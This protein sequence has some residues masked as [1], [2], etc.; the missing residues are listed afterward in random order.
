[1]LPITE[2]TRVHP[3]DPYAA[4]KRA[5]DAVCMSDVASCGMKIV[6]TRAFSH[7]GPRRDVLGEIASFARQIARAERRMAE[8]EGLS[9]YHSPEDMGLLT[10][11]RL[12]VLVHLTAIT[13]HEQIES[14]RFETLRL[15]LRGKEFALELARRAG[16]ARF[17]C[18]SSGKV[19][20]AAAE[21]VPLTGGLHARPLSILE[22]SKHAAERL[23]DC[24]SE[25]DRS[26]IALRIFNVYGPGQ[27]PSFLSPAVVE[28]LSTRPSALEFGDVEARRDD[29]DI[30][31]VILAFEA[32]LFGAPTGFSVRNVATGLV[33]SA[34]GIAAEIL[35]LAGLDIP[36]VGH[37]RRARPD[38]L[39]IE[40][41]S[42]ARITK[43]LSWAPRVVLAEGL[44]RVWEAR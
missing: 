25:P 14:E 8:P 7:E 19:Y 44:R 9:E 22:K 27:R 13:A 16:C 26:Q 1:M 31:D 36:V 24:W 33:T 41:G 28:R 4:S 29:V 34:R 37:P 35:A 20:G 18:A 15:N 3:I 38:E 5:Q 12:D 42:H 6:R 30:D 11:G 2:E 32:T 39:S 43:A 10:L 17:V 21:T 23:R 40:P